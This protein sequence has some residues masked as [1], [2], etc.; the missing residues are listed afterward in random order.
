M[1]TISR[2]NGGSYSYQKPSI[3]QNNSKLLQHL[4]NLKF[5]QLQKLFPAVDINK[6]VKISA[7]INR[8]HPLNL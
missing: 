5:D 3:N 4:E 8:K 6:K 1:I 7:K 2:K